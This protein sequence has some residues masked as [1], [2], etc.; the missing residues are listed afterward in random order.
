MVHVHIQN[1]SN[2]VVDYVKDKGCFQGQKLQERMMNSS[3]DVKYFLEILSWL[4]LL[5]AIHFW[6]L[7]GPYSE[8]LW[9]FWYIVKITG[10]FSLHCVGFHNN[11][12]I[13]YSSKNI[14]V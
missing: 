4:P 10:N 13:H 9:L 2:Q 7:L 1:L 12:N 8:I 14:T 3:P 6:F 11:K 5:L